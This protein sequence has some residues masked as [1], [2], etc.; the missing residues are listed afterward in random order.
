M[1]IKKTKKRISCLLAGC[2]LAGMLPSA[3]YARETAASEA[4]AAGIETVGQSD[5]DGGEYGIMP[6]N[7]IGGGYRKLP[8][9]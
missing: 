2:M 1:S 3:A 4:P 8:R 9:L 6:Q 5:A 7:D